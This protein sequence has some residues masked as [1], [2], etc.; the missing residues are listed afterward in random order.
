MT[1][2][3]IQ[4]DEIYQTKH[5]NNTEPV[6]AGDRCY[7]QHLIQVASNL[8]AAAP[9]NWAEVRNADDLRKELNL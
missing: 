7:P 6:P 2:Q 8:L 4:P 9:V 5:D 3:E 1:W